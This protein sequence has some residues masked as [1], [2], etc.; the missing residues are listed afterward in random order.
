LSEGRPEETALS[1]CKT[2]LY[3]RRILF[4]VS[5]EPGSKEIPI[6]VSVVGGAAMLWGLKLFAE[7]VSSTSGPSGSFVLI[8]IAGGFLLALAGLV[9]WC[10][11]SCK[12]QRRRLSATLLVVAAL[13]FC[14]GLLGHVLATF[15]AIAIP[16]LLLGLVV[17]I[18]PGTRQAT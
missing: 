9:T 4:A 18:V 2:G 11:R 17:R 10:R 7:Y 14:V 5:T 6:V 3:A 15:F 12:T 16:S 13:T 8:L 1:F